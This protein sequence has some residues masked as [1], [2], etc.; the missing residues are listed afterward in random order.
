VSINFDWIINF[1][2][3]FG[4]E[5]NKPISFLLLCVI[6]LI[7]GCASTNEPDNSGI[8]PLTVGE[9]KIVSSNENFALKLFRR[10]N[11]EE[12]NNNIVISPLSISMA[13]GM[14]VNGANG[15]TRDSML[16][17]L[18]LQGIS[19]DD[20]NDS[21]RTLI[22]LLLGLDSK[23]QFEIGNSI[24]YRD[25][26]EFEKTFFDVCAKNFDALVNGLNFED[27]ESV[28]TINNWIKDKT[29][30][31]IEKMIEK[32][33]SE[34]VM[35]LIN[36]IYFKGLWTYQFDSKYTKDDKFYGLTGISQNCKMMN[37]SAK[38]QYTYNEHF[39]IVDL[40]YGSGKY[41]MTVLL[42][43][44]NINDGIQQLTNENYSNWIGNLTKDSVI[45]AFPKFKSEYEKSLVDVLT[46]L[47]MSN[48]FIP[49]MADFT[50]MH[51]LVGKELF[52]SDVKHKTF[53][54]VDEA[55]TEA[56][57]ATVVEIGYTSAPEVK[58][59]K[60]NRPFLFVLRENHSGTILFIGKIV[61]L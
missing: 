34:T 39:Q 19:M 18:E 6:V 60:I 15:S 52:I 38:L 35:F 7:S 29:N 8:R 24:W 43:S 40:P 51:K 25:T 5:M 2:H 12:L 27:P 41:S 49:G 37:M 4:A 14:T 13:L 11:T 48:A 44:G 9:Q 16:R 58:I 33:S 23:V 30:G 46:A 26:W 1:N 57:A 17:T 22:D 53:V 47:G 31:K 21:Y 59:M 50:N 3:I 32:I 45:L 36:A 10:M 42:P 56:A 28:N 55:G 54:E 61:E 20:V